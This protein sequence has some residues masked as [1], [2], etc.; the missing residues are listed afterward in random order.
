MK[1]KKRERKVFEGYI[2]CGEMNVQKED[3]ALVGAVLWSHYG[4]TPMEQ[5]VTHGAGTA[6]GRRIA[7][8][9]LQ[10]FVDSLQGHIYHFFF[11]Y[12]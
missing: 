5:V 3:A 2:V 6:W 12:I 8:Q 1:K 7:L 9:V 10:L 4:S 11:L